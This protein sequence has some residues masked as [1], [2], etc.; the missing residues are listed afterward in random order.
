MTKSMTPI[1]QVFHV[2]ENGY[3]GFASFIFNPNPKNQFRLVTSL[4]EDYYQIPYDP[5]RNSIGNQQLA[6]AGASP[7]YDLRDG[8]HEPD[9]YVTFS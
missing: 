4:R 7:S 5:D 9:G 6:V 2:A 8:E 1:P 3:G